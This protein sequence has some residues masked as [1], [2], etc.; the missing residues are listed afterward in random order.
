M[1]EITNYIIPELTKKD[2]VPGNEVKWCPGC[3]DYTV[4]SS[5]HQILPLIGKKKEDIAFISGIGCSS[6]FPY[7][8]DTYGFH[9]I[10][11]RA[12]AIAS[13][14]K[15]ANPNL[16]V[17]QITGDGDCMAIGGNHF[18]HLIRRNIDINV[19]LLNNKIYGLTKGQASPTTPIGSKT[20]TSPDGTI[21]PPFRPGLL[22]VGAQGTFFARL[23][24]TNPKMIREALIEA[25]NHKGTSVVEILQ[26]CVIFN[27][28]VHSIVTAKETRDDHQIFLKHGEPM[29]FGENNSKGIILN[30]EKLELEQVVIGENGITEKD[31]LVHD[32]QESNYTKQLMLIQ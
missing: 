29:L 27:N 20:K 31:I 30:K 24:D 21:E 1:G 13:G 16:S 18:I 26:N 10:H 5:V 23:I 4:L 7:Y 14:V 12:A 8:V 2:F 17:W 9:T 11:G 15:L 25:A 28:Q 3:G 32:A 22:T 6:R 19:V